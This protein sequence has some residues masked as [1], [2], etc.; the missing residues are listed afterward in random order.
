M[1]TNEDKHTLH[2]DGWD[3]VFDSDRLRLYY[4]DEEFVSLPLA[5]RI[6]G[7]A[8]KLSKWRRVAEDRFTSSIVEGMIKGDATI[9]IREGHTAFWIETDETY[10]DTFTYFPESTFVGNAWQTYVSDGWDRLWNLDLDKEIGISSA[11][12]DIM[13]V[14]GAD[15]AGLTDPGDNPPTFVW[16]MPARAF[17]MKT[18]RGFVGFSM[19]GAL[20]VGVTRLAVQDRKLSVHFDALRPACREA[21]MPVIYLVPGL[22]GDYDVLSE[23]RAISDRLGIT[24]KKS[25]IIRPGG[26]SPSSNR[27]WSTRA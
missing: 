25:G 26:P 2:C 5:P 10:F 21:G 4:R 1:K 19:P 9:A 7:R 18:G 12:L 22:S 3:Y 23:H 15:G 16:N 24:R 13:N 27:I 6:N 17:S 14:F 8:V 11:Y 20:P